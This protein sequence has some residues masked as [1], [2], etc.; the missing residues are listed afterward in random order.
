MQLM[1]FTPEPSLSPLVKGYWL[2]QSD[3]VLS[4]AIK[5]LF[6]LG[7]IEIIF[8]LKTPFSRWQNS[9][10]FPEK[11][12]F[13]EGQQSGI[14]TVK[15]CGPMKTVGITLYPWAAKYFLL[16]SPDVFTDA[17]YPA[18]LVDSHLVGLY[19]LIS[20]TELSEIPELL[21]KY[22]LAK[23]SRMSVTLSGTDIKF[24][25]LLNASMQDGAIADLKKGWDLSVR[26]LEKKCLQ[27]TGLSPLV[28]LRKA[29]MK[30]AVKQCLQQDFRSFT[31]VA[32][33][34]GYFDQ[35]HFIKDFNA[36]FGQTPGQVFQQEG[37]FLE[38][39]L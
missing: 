10:W 19:E 22:L 31:D 36:Y 15:Q 21:D 11:L 9:E 33:R 38:N 32:H 35:S 6:P 25:A 28:L 20:R 30:N 29:R 7:A 13:V 2:L 17:N 26:Y 1:H 34:C 39:F 16:S 8:H 14:I 4:P 5:T 3:A 18:E 23:L 27:H 37:I 24:I 12:M